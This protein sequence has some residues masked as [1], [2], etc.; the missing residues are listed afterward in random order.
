MKKYSVFLVLS[1]TLWLFWPSSAGAG[2]VAASG[3]LERL[4]R[5][6]NELA[7][8]LYLKLGASEGGNLFFS[9]FSVFSALAMSYAGAEGETAGQIKKVLGFDGSGD[10]LHQAGAGLMDHFE[11]L[12]NS[13]EIKLN[14]A[15][16]LWVQKG[17]PLLVRF[18]KTVE[19]SY[20]A[21]AE[22]VDYKNE[23]QGAAKKINDW[24]AEKTQG[25]ISDLVS[26]LST[27]TRLLLVNAVYFKG[28]W[29]FQFDEELT[30][31]DDFL[32]GAGSVRTPLMRQ[33]GPLKYGEDENLQILELPYMGESLSML[34]ILPRQ[35][36]PEALVGVEKNLSAANLEIW[37]ALLEPRVEVRVSLPKFK[38]EW[39]ANSLK[40]PLQALG[41]TDAF[42]ENLADFSLVS[43]V[44]DLYVSD[45]LHKALV[46][47]NEKGSEAAAATAV[48]M[49]LTFSPNFGEA[50]PLYIFRADHPFI[51]LIQDNASGVILFMGRMNDPAS[52]K[53]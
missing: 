1:A 44:P 47:V 33:N 20:R 41:L 18:R 40:D 49:N 2:P 10:D 29:R 27:R 38:M 23:P 37:K 19:G 46:E 51:F 16:S 24:V 22:E 9:P 4:A 42:H 45:V 34:V 7:C 13:G 50:Q 39:G 15:N 30:E 52:A 21:A 17:Y 8:Q 53:L 48:I 14:V 3:K 36:T 31:D 6:N 26:G 5:A 11:G 35:R 12:G 28:D 32:R 25:L 43:G